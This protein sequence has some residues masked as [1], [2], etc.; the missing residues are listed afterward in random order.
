MRSDRTVVPVSGMSTGTA[1]QLYLALRFASIEDYLERA[2]AL[3][4]VADDLFINFD[5]ERATAGFL[6]LEELSQKTQVLF[7]THH[8]HLVDIAQRTLGASVNLI[9]LTDHEATA[10]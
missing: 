3:P 2:D 5:D 6:L 1:D 9:T 7:F 10:A 4:F 8:Q